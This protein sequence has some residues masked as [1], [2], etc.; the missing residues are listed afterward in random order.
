MKVRTVVPYCLAVLLAGCVPIVS[1]HPL[2]TTETIT[3]EEKLL[4]TWVEEADKP[5][6]TWEFARLEDGA[7]ERLPED[8]KDQ[9]AKC[10]RVNVADDKGGKGS[11][12]ACLVKLQDKLFLDVL[13]DKFPSGEQN[14]E[15]M[16]FTYNAFFFLRVHTFVRVDVLGDQLKL[17]LT[18]DE[19]FKKLLEAEP[20]A[21][22]YTEADDHVI[23]TASTTELQT[24]VTKYAG[25]EKLFPNEVTLSP[26]KDKEGL[27]P[28][29]PSNK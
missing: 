5:Q 12:V 10:Y 23:L 6:V 28:A 20:K 14:A 13:P 24:F 15:T 19:Q 16:K 29:T 1:L 11:L 27:P 22:G 2:F 3:F 18:D 17:R 7:A 25:N 9:A 8:L 26:R 21:V 4:G